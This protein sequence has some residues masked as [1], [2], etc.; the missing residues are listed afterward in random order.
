M[1]SPHEKSQFPWG[2]KSYNKVV[3]QNPMYL[4]SL[5]NLICLAF[6]LLSM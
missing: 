3:S 1:G 4:S 5:P 2:K 6:V